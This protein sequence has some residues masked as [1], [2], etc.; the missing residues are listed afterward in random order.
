MTN[1]LRLASSGWYVF[2]EDARSSAAV[3][4]LL[5]ADACWHFAADDWYRRRPHRWQRARWHDWRREEL[6]LADEQTRLIA[7]AT[8]LRT[9]RPFT[10][11]AS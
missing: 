3:L 10:D 11:A 1:W 6:A 7:A 8:P 9:L 4:D 5:A 2:L